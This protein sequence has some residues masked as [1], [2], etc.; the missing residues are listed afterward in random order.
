MKDPTSVH[1]VSLQ[2]RYAAQSRCFGCG[3]ANTLGLQIKSCVQG[4]EVVADWQPQSHHEAFPGMLNGGII[5]SLL[6]CHSNWTAAWHLMQLSQ[7]NHPPCTVTADY[8]VQLLRPTPTVGPVHLS[9]RVAESKADRAVIEATLS[10]DGKVCA[11]CRGTFV[12][13]KPGHPAYHR[14]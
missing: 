12:A 11:R 8:A 7:A 6:D 9:A 14:W 13:V 3:P 4:D 1:L 10:V 2:D 5:G